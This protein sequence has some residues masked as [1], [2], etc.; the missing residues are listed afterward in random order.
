MAS[1][2][3]STSTPST[4]TIT[5]TTTTT[6][7]PSSKELRHATPAQLQAAALQ[8]LL[9]DTSKPVHIPS[10]PK[11]GVKQLRAP[12][13]MMRNV[14]GSSA[15]AGSGEFHVYKESRRREYERLK[16]MDE[17]EAYNKAK[18]AA[19]DR[20]ATYESQAEAKTAKNRLKRQ[21]K[22]HAQRTTSASGAGEKADQ[23]EEEKD[24]GAILGDKKR[25]LGSSTAASGGTFT[26][27]SAKERQDEDQDEDEEAGP[28]DDDTQR[29]ETINNGAFVQDAITVPQVAPAI[30]AGVKI[31]DDDDF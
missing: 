20:Q 17:E 6:S 13:E 8:R 15:G 3:R 26:F 23:V 30:E 11:E 2:S 12:R 27:K 16:L 19:L 28:K 9:K 31:V 10:P 18:K 14:Q 25:K 5:T 1:P 24:D 22:K 4:T 7:I 29:I 21:K